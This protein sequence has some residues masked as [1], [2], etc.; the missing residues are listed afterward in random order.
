M[1]ALFVTD[2]YL[3]D[4]LGI[5]YLSSYLKQAGHEVDIVQTKEEDVFE[6]IET[7]DPDMVCYSVTTGK[8]VFYRELNKQIRRYYPDIISVF[9]GPHITFFPQFCNDPDIDI[10]VRGE[11][12][13]AIVD[14]A[15]A[16]EK[17]HDL[18]S[19]D[20]VV[21]K[22]TIRPL[23]PLKD[24]ATLLFPDRELMYKY[25]KNYNNPIKN[26]MAS[27][28]CPM[29]CKYC[30]N[31]KYK[32]MYG[33]KRSEIRPVV[34]VIEEVQRLEK[35]PLDL[36]FF[37]D[38]IFPI[39]DR[40]WIASFISGYKLTKM[41]PF[42]IQVRIEMVNEQVI[43]DLKSVGL[44]GVTF[45]IESGNEELRRSLLNRKMSN[46]TIINGAKILKDHDVRVRIENMVGIPNE[47]WADMKST[48]K[49]NTRCKPDIA[50]ASLF[51]PYPGTELGDKCISSGLFDGDIDDIGGSFFD[52]YR[53]KADNPKRI[54]RL[55][56]LFA[57]IV[58]IP[59]LYWLA[60]PLAS[61]PFDK[62]Y[63]KVYQWVK[64]YL[65]EKRLY[66]TR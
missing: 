30:Y 32:E 50:W 20:N 25:Y 4:V 3:I 34:L 27:F 66:Q 61:L 31:P 52:T 45:A 19:I 2:S 56:K 13:D 29:D 1:R 58:M 16:Y 63:R 33:I 57:L 55:Q 26:V 7:Y 15:N 59:P 62:F 35:Y 9:G 38:D 53:L 12:F 22:K 44:H 37:Q 6:K 51:Q 64:T 28:L 41:T 46:E 11:G 49:L 43:K 10:G 36:L 42:H 18:L 60:K 8:H 23:R 21:W 14:I 54:E 48:L 65:Y 47:T 5:G 17:C 24:K 40:D 39:Y